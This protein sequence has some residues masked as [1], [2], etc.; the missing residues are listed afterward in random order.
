M[1]FKTVILFGMVLNGAFGVSSLAQKLPYVYDV[2]NTGAIFPLPSMP[3]VNSLP[4]IT[5]FPDPFLWA[6]S[7][8]RLLY[9]SDWM[10]RR[11]QISAQV[12]HYEIG[13]KPSRPDTMTASYTN[14]TLTVNVTVNGQLLTLASHVTL[15]AGTGP[16]PAVIGMNSPT[17]SIPSTIFSSRNI[18]QITFTHNQ[19]TTY[20]MVND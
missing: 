19:V 5:G 4:V 11:A 6:D 3:S 14:N 15:P 7:S 2:E 1:K 12:Q 20:A 16:F 13:D 9:K 17:G 8:S 10:R 18:A